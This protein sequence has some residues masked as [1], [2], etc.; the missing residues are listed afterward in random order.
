MAMEKVSNIVQS[1]VKQITS[2]GRSSSPS[3]KWKTPLSEWQRN[4]INGFMAKFPSVE[5]L[6][7]FFAPANLPYAIAHEQDCVTSPCITLNR[8]DEAYQTQGCAQTIIRNLIVGVYSMSTAR[9]PMQQDAANNAAG[10]FVA[11]FGNECT[12]YGAMLYFG[13][14][15]TEYKS[16]FAQFDVQDILQQY[17]KKFVPWWRSRLSRVA[18]EEPRTKAINGPQGKEGLKMY[19]RTEI[20]KGRDLKG[21]YLY[22]S[23]IITD[24]M[25]QQAETEIKNGV[26]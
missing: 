21:G 4:E 25:I 11:K 12:L 18:N 20:N 22:Q 2:Q 17:G 24:A 15:L 3:R 8:V 13:N 14:Y 19:I 6:Y 1:Q 26:F 16:T 23:G 5:K 7:R 9:E 10:L